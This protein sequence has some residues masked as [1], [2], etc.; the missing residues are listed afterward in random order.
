M[1]EINKT[2]FITGATGFV[3]SYLLKELLGKLGPQSKIFVFSRKHIDS[4]DTRVANIIGSLQDIEEYAGPLKESNYVFHLA[5]DATFGNDIDYHA[6]NT[7]PTQKIVDILKQSTKLENF[8]FVSTIGAL[9][10]G[11]EDVCTAPLSVHSIPAP[12]S[13]YGTSKLAA[14]QYIKESGISHTIVRPTWVYGRNMRVRSHLSAFV[15]MVHA[16]SKMINFNF[17]GVVSLIHVEDLAFALSNILE[18]KQAIKKTY[19]AE[20]EAL[21]IG[22]I[23]STFYEHIKGE[24]PKQIPVSRFSFVLG[25]LHSK[26]P[27]TISNLFLDYLFAKDD[28]FRRDLLLNRTPFTLDEKAIDV[29]STHISV[30][31]YWLVTGAN[32]GIGYE[33][34]CRLHAAGKQLIL[35]DKELTNLTG[36][37]KQLIIHCDLSDKIKNTDYVRLA[38][39]CDIV[40]ERA[41]SLSE[42]FVCKAYTDFK[43]ML[44]DPEI[45]FINICTPSGMHPE[46][47]IICLKA[48][49]NVLCEKPMALTTKDATEMVRVAKEANKLLYVVQ[50]NRYNPPVKLVKKLIAEG[51]LG[52]PI[53]CVVN[54]L[55][56]RND[57]YY[58]S[59]P[60]RGTLKLDGG[61]I[62]TQAT[63]FIDLMLMF[64]GK[65][66]EVFSHMGTLNHTIEI[67]DTGVVSAKFENGAFGVL[68]Y[69]TCATKK[70]F[71]GSITLIFS[72][73][74]IKIGGEFI[75]TIEYF[76]VE[77]VDSYELE[78]TPVS[79]NDYGTYR[80]SMS[81]HDKIFKDILARQN[82]KTT[83]NNLV[84]G[85]EAIE[86]I[87]FTEAAIRSAAENRVV[88]FE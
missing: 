43:Q 16:K 14:E 2:V 10:R 37:G 5:A 82:D 68:N 60:W 7:L 13:A 81:N 3:G 29:I 54:M 86:T 66:A 58:N 28:N 23:F 80:G 85:D 24:P 71:E 9:D 69:T 31:G 41:Q 56:N 21:P 53:M 62:Y 77:G 61:T 47:A 50:Q 33:L 75:N 4:A 64:M 87:R 48:G 25:K 42:K 15:S 59:D 8:I 67:E 63:H 74:T 20:T 65:P 45:D 79:A 52:K 76:Q 55:W 39:V 46:H 18:N 70:N 1:G 34:A 12:T 19:I 72:K 27:L 11:K 30:T 84:F 51:K 35:V 22:K 38:A 88:K 44:K 40:P 83:D 73:G 78:A 26:L 6:V 57:A 36:F 32:S 17:P 49:K